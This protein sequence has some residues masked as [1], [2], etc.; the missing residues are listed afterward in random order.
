MTRIISLWQAAWEK[1]LASSAP[2]W[3]TDPRFPFVFNPFEGSIAYDIRDIPYR[4]LSVFRQIALPI[5]QI[6]EADISIT[7]QRLARGEIG[8]NF[9]HETTD[10]LL[11]H[12]DDDGLMLRTNRF[13][14][15]HCDTLLISRKVEPQLMTSRYALAQL[16]WTGRGAVTEFH[17]SE[18]FVDHFHVHMFPRQFAP[19]AGVGGSFRT[20]HD[21]GVLEE[22]RLA[23]YPL[24]H[25]AVASRDINVLCEA[26][27]LL[28]DELEAQ[29]RLFYQLAL[30]H[31]SMYIVVFM[32]WEKNQTWPFGFSGIG[33]VQD[34]NLDMPETQ[35]TAKLRKIMF[36]RKEHASIR[37]KFW[38][39]WNNRRLEQY[40]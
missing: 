16:R 24:P 15:A 11:V 12:P 5:M 39:Q 18:T 7:R 1:R 32:L 20:H 13:P 19:I 25:I 3:H 26:M 34:P 6:P 35:V 21:D 17:R 2:Y 37:R 36:T 4:Q 8:K 14:K 33:V 27:M 23:S 22:G 30:K 38:S 29:D 40:K 31:Q 9:S 10:P 28:N